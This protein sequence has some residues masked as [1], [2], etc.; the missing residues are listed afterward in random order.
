MKLLEITIK[1]FMPYRGEQ[2]IKFPQNESQNVMLIFGENMRGKTSFLNAIRWGFYGVALGRH[3]RP[4][5]KESL[6]NVD[7]VE[8]GDCSM[9]IVL[10]FEHAEKIYELRRQ[11]D[12]KAHVSVPRGDSDFLET[13]L[14]RVNGEVLPGDQVINEI[15]QVIPEEVSRFFLFDGELLQEYENLLIEESEQGEK[16]KEHIEQA[17]GVPALIHGRD[18][19]RTLLKSAQKTQAK[20]AQKN[21]E[22]AQYAEQQEELDSKLSSLEENKK[23]LQAL[24]AEKQKDVDKID[25]ELKNTAAVQRKK[26]ELDRLT[27]KRKMIEEQISYEKETQ[28]DLLKTLWK[29]VLYKST[30]PKL[31]KLRSERDELQNSITEK[32]QIETIIKELESALRETLCPTCSQVVPDENSRKI[33]ERLSELKSSSNSKSVDVGRLRQITGKIDQ[34]SKVVSESESKRFIRAKRNED[35]LEIQL[36]E[37]ETKLDELADEIKEFDTEQIMRQREKREQLLK[38]LNRIESDLTKVKNEIEENQ[39][40]QD[41]IA[42][43]ISRSA[44]A[45]GQLSSRRVNIYQQLEQTF[46]AGIVKLRDKLKEEVQQRSSAAFSELTTESTY[47]GLKINSNY[48]LSILDHM[49]RQLKERSAGAEQIVAL[50]L[51]DG[52][53]KTARTSGPIVMDTPLGRLDPRHRRNVLKYL[54]KM[55]EQV[56]LLVH[57]GE[58]DP[59]RDLSHFAEKIGARYQ[60][61]RISSTESRIVKG[62]QNDRT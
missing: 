8:D 20:D 33:Q 55:A 13:S 62:D 26:G 5:P 18:E 19:L 3:L 35:K 59:E 23:E 36:I 38:L 29:D 48:G 37:V 53:N 22:L 11:I 61:K 25:D 45:Q 32:T 14:L 15:N 30:R 41:H 16:I 28:R 10:K 43:I 52:L 17:L 57:E 27:D 58:I 49:G 39:R 24:Q 9:S 4:I 31:E 54:P 34:L 12:K 40:K 2:V 21:K 47:S 1:N 6:I 42:S 7:A 51:I 46:S 44:G 50:S 56:V 60:I